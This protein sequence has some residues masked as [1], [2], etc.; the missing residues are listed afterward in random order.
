MTK[1]QL[2][3]ANKVLIIVLLVTMI[4]NLIGLFTLLQNADFA[5][6]SPNVVI[7]TMVLYAIATIAYIVI[8][9][10][11][12]D[13]TLLLYVSC[14]S[15]LFL[16]AF[17]MLTQSSSTPFPYIAPILMV[18]IMFQN[19][20]II[21][22]TAIAQLVINFA[23]IIQTVMT[24]EN[25]QMEIEGIS[26]EAI[27][28]IL[29]CIG[30]IFASKLLFKFNQ[31]HSSVLEEASAKNESLSKYVV[32][33]AEN[34]ITDVT[35]TQNKLSKI[36]D[37]TQIINQSLSDISSS[38]FSTAEAVEH[39]TEMTQSIAEQID[40]ANNLTTDIVSITGDVSSNIDSGAK[41]VHELNNKAQDS[42]KSIL[43]MKSAAEELQ[44]KSIE[45]RSITD[46]ILNISSQTNLL[47]LNASI[48]AAR[49]GEAGKGFAVVADEIRTL[50]DQTREATESI[51]HI[52]D[53]LASEANSVVSQVDLNVDNSKEQGKLIEETSQHFNEINNKVSMLVENISDVSSKMAM[54]KDSNN[55][56]VESVH[57]LS[58]TSEEVSASTENALQTSSDNVDMVSAFKTTMT[59]IEEK[60]SKL[61]SHN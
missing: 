17:S 38:T 20:R 35:E 33:N 9:I 12:K 54:I 19:R 57:T 49:A 55:Q 25:M 27:C 14:F 42:S 37:T 15:F 4:F 22:I 45:V 41:V 13:D 16:Y 48:E 44:Q 8:Y 3:Q 30:S 1:N 5:G 53:T 47:A 26:L 39:Q 11:K 28:S 24:A 10:A 51:T 29:C 56:I 21:N 59:S 58:A 61:A 32:S 60:I 50:A 46:I 36:L 34:V 31:E 2:K 43:E 6:I 7:L 18:Y 40:E 52:L 23:I